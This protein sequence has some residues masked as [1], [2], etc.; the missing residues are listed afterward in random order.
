MSNFIKQRHLSSDYSAHFGTIARAR[1]DFG[2]NFATL[3]EQVREQH[4]EELK[5]DQKQTQELEKMAKKNDLANTRPD[6]PRIDRIVLYI[7]DL[8]RCPEATVSEVL[9]AIHLLLA[10]PLFVVVVGVNSRWLVHS[11]RQ[12]I[13][14]F[15]TPL[16]NSS[17]ERGNK[18]ILE[19]ST[20]LFR[21]D[22]QI[23][24]ALRPMAQ[25]GFNELIYNL[26]EQ[27]R[28]SSSLLA[29]YNILSAATSNSKPDG[30]ASHII[31]P[32]YC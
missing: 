19:I 10:F 1:E 18:S 11:L 29:P 28:I 23:P 20:Q 14:A 4:S 25:S 8:D 7:D 32:E 2:S 30:S 12:H 6:L 3:L 15:Q 16:D 13:K 24:Y 31:E 22:L 9:Q 27:Q 5:M 21:K 17:V 26:T